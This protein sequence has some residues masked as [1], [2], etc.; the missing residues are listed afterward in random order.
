MSRSPLEIA[1]DFLSK[2]FDPALVADAADRL[3]AEDAEY[4]SLNF[5]NPPLR[6]LMPW[7]GADKGRQ[8]FV[9]TFTNVMTRWSLEGFDRRPPR[10]RDDRQTV[11]HLGGNSD[12]GIRHT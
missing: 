4:V 1:Q 5:D 2:A 7:A 12:H 3:V 9:Y 10:F 6:R 11:T 8:A